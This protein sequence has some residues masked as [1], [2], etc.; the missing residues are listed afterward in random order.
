MNR[1]SWKYGLRIQALLD[2][3]GISQRR[4]ST[5]LNL[6]PN[7]VNG[8]IRNRRVPDCI[9]LAQI[10]DYLG[11]NIDYLLGN[12]DIRVYPDHSLSSDEHLLLNYYRSLDAAHRDML[13]ELSVALYV[14]QQKDRTD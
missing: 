6:S 8:Y 5:D 3:Q 14:K 12:T 4:L 2:E 13:L 1:T 10:A 11:T 7:T 9:T